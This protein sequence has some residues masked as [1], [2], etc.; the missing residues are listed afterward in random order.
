MN[1]VHFI[2]FDCYFDENLCTRR[3][4]LFRDVSVTS[5]IRFNVHENP[6]FDARIQLVLS[7]YQW[8]KNHIFFLSFAFFAL[9]HISNDWNSSKNAYCFRLQ[10][11]HGICLTDFYFFAFFDRVFSLSRFYRIYSHP[12]KSHFFSHSTAHI[13]S[14]KSY[15]NMCRWTVHLS[16]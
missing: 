4:A 9:L 6:D 15:S 1:D 10:F 12:N 5:N 16:F 2:S 13:K 8:G 11:W 7:V 3:L 14:H